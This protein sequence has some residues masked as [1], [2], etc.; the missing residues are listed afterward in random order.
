[1]IRLYQL[2]GVKRPY[3]EPVS[4][5][6]EGAR[7]GREGRRGG[8]GGERRE[9]REGKILHVVQRGHIVGLSSDRSWRY[10]KGVARIY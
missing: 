3:L 2:C 6:R 10:I 4:W 7:V 8:R 1:M 9:R 5:R